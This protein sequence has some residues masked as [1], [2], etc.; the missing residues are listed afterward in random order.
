MTDR[1]CKPFAITAKTLGCP[2]F[3]YTRI[4]V[5]NFAS[6]DKLTAAYVNALWDTGAECSL[7]TR[8]L[9]VRLGFDFRTEI[10]SKGVAGSAN[11]AYGYVSVALVSNGDTVETITAIVDSL[12]RN[13]YSFIL[14]M[15]FIRKGTLAISS[16]KLSTT[17]S[18]TIPTSEH[19]D[20]VKTLAGDNV[21]GSYIPLSSGVED[22]E[23]YRGTAVLDLIIPQ[24]TE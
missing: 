13:E 20:F 21:P 2:R 8:E 15:D 1:I 10:L 16:S 12:P 9:A 14:G 6:Y 4:L 19:L 17:L 22:R 23:V 7:M 11:A 18:F 24:K 3:L 5:V